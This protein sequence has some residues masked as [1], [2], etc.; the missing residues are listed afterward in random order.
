MYGSI[1]TFWHYPER[2]N[3]QWQKYKQHHRHLSIQSEWM[4]RYRLSRV[5]FILFGMTEWTNNYQKKF[6]YHHRYIS[7]QSEWMSRYLWCHAYFL[8]WLK[9]WMINGK[10][11]NG[12]IDVYMLKVSECLDIYSDICTFWYDWKDKWLLEKYDQHNRYLLY[13]RWMNV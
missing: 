6:E 7:I 5:P 8:V 2:M 4:Y 12:T 11:T 13:S 3:G 9:G 10:R 1:C